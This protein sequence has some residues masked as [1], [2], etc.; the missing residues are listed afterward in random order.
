[1]TSGLSTPS[2]STHPCHDISHEREVGFSPANLRWRGSEELA[3]SSS[4]RTLM[5]TQERTK[6]LKVKR[7]KAPRRRECPLSL[8]ACEPSR[9][10]STQLHL[11]SVPAR[12]ACRSKS[13]WVMGTS[14]PQGGWPRQRVGQERALGTKRREH[15]KEIK[16]GEQKEV[17]PTLRLPGSHQL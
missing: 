5:R 4:L 2:Q 1:M 9:K 12:R 11:C 14:R 15:R 6:A 7:E 13:P 3:H 10:S 8:S 17:G 16:V